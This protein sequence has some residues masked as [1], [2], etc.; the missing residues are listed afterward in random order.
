MSNREPGS[1]NE[2]VFRGV[3]LFLTI[4]ICGSLIG[5][6][7]GWAIGNGQKQ[8]MIAGAVFGGAIPIVIG[9]L[10]AS[11]DC[12]FVLILNLTIDRQP[13][14]TLA[15]YL[16]YFLAA[17]LAGVSPFMV[18]L[19]ASVGLLIR[20]VYTFCYLRKIGAAYGGLR[21]V[22]T[23]IGSVLFYIVVVMTVFA[24]FG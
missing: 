7:A 5:L 17:V 18:N 24:V 19:A 10:L 13:K 6:A 8:A 22:L 2:N 20:L 16:G 23:V 12:I 3:Q 9:L 14:K 21:T 4:F 11:L 15:Q 1:F